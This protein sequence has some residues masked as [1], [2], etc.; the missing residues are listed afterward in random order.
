MSTDVQVVLKGAGQSMSCCAS[1]A[2]SPGPDQ[3]EWTMS[4][5]AIDCLWL[6]AG[7]M[8]QRQP[9][10]SAHNTLVELCPDASCCCQLLLLTCTVLAVH[11]VP[12][13]G[14]P[15]VAGREAELQDPL[16]IARHLVLCGLLL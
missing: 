2:C 13:A 12:T 8:T 10:D 5:I 14:S 3:K 15:R 7:G 11:A 9:A 6:V 4:D 1:S 16:Q